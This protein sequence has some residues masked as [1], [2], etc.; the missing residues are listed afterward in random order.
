MISSGSGGYYA[1]KVARILL[2]GCGWPLK[3]P[4]KILSPSGRQYKHKNTIN[5]ASAWHQL[6]I[7]FNRVEEVGMDKCD[8]CNRPSKCDFC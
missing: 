5:S 8:F 6:G 4:F 3:G 7:R 1:S 2:G